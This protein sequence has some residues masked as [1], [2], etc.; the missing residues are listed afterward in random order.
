[1]L[2]EQPRQIQ[3]LHALRLLTRGT[4]LHPPPKPWK[5]WMLHICIHIPLTH[6]EVHE[7]AV[8]GVVNVPL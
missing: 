1:M 6:H 4:S 2:N 8:G 7:V 3:Q 5:L